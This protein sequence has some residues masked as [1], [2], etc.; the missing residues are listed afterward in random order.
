MSKFPPPKMG[1]SRLLWVFVGLKGLQIPT[2]ADRF[3]Q[4]S[5]NLL[6][7]YKNWLVV[8]PDFLYPRV[9]SNIFTYS[10]SDY[11]DHNKFILTI[12]NF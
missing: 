3:P 7:S 5:R 11:F 6:N 4:K 9:V 8:S 1:K 10:Y 12:I 2:K